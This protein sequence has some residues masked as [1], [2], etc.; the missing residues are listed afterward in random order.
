MLPP[1][2]LFGALTVCD[3]SVAHASAIVTLLFF[4]GPP[5]RTCRFARWKVV[6]TLVAASSAV[7]APVVASMVRQAVGRMAQLAAEQVTETYG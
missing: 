3:A 7:V 6:C 1:P 5:V 2:I 4:G